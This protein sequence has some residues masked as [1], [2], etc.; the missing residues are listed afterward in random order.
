[1]NLNYEFYM[2]LSC[3]LQ[4]K[5]KIGKNTVLKV[6]KPLYRV[7]EVSNYWFKTYYLYYIQ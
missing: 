6:L 5:L 4:S 1:M 2:Y 3:E 7:L